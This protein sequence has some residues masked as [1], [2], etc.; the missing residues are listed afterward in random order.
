MIVCI[1]KLCFGYDNWIDL[2]GIALIMSCCEYKCIPKKS[3]T[4]ALISRIPLSDIEMD[5]LR[6]RSSNLGVC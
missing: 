5:Y 4:C 3:C 2:I 1:F 6:E